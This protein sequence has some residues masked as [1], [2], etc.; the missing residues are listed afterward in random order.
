MSK[1]SGTTRTSNSRTAHSSI[2]SG[3]KAAVSKFNGIKL[4]SAQAFQTRQSAMVDALGMLP[5]GTQVDLSKQ[6]WTGNTVSVSFVKDSK[7]TFVQKSTADQGNL[8]SN[9]DKWTSQSISNGHVDFN[10][11]VKKYK[12]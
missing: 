9:F 10:M 1:G 6:G 7:G 11:T 2:G 8:E 5:S 12:K 4:D 3:A